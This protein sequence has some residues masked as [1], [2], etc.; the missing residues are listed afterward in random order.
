MISRTVVFILISVASTLSTLAQTIKVTGKIVD[1]Q[2]G[3][4]LPYASVYINHTTIGAYANEQGEFTIFHVPVGTHELMASFVGYMP[5]KTVLQA[6]ENQD[7]TLQIGLKLMTLKA[8]EITAKRD[9]GWFDQFEKF[10]KLFLGTGQSARL[11]NIINPFGLTF[12]MNK[13][14]GFIAE[15]SEPLEID[16][17]YLGYR[18]HYDLSYFAVSKEKYFAKGYIRFEEMQT[19]DSLLAKRWT[20]NRRRS[21]AGSLGHFLTSITEGKIAKNGYDTYDDRSGLNEIVRLARFQSNLDRTIFT[22]TLSK[23]VRASKDSSTFHVSVPKRL[24]IHYKNGRE[25]SKIYWDVSYPVSWI[26]VNGGDLILARDGTVLNPIQMTLSGQMLE[27]RVSGLLPNDYRPKIDKETYLIPTIAQSDKLSYLG[28]KPYLHTDR[29]YY[30]PGESMWFKAYMKYNS[31]ITRDSL[32]RVLYVDLLDKN[33]SVTNSKAYEIRD[34]QCIGDITFPENIQPGDYTLRAYTRWML[35]FDTTF[36]YSVPIKI[37]SLTQMVRTNSEYKGAENVGVSLQSKKEEYSPREMVELSVDVLDEFDNPLAAHLSVSVTDL[38]QA[39]PAK[40]ETSI[41]KKFHMPETKMQLPDDKAFLA[42]QQGF[43]LSG[44]FISA[45]GKKIKGVLTFVQHG[46]ANRFEITT[47]DNGHFFIP[48]M[49]LFDT[50]SI[51]YSAKAYKGRTGKVIFDSVSVSPQT[52]PAIP[53]NV[54]VYET[55]KQKVVD[56]LDPAI[57]T[58]L[59]QS[60][61]IQDKHISSARRPT[62]TFDVEVTGEWLRAR[63]TIDIVSAMQTRVPGMRVIVN[64]V[65]GMPQRFIQL[66]GPSSLAKDNLSQPIVLIDGQVLSDRDESLTDQISRLSPEVI[67]RIEVTKYGNGAAYGARGSNGIIAIYTRRPGNSVTDKVAD[68]DDANLTPLKF[69]GFSI[70]G[71]FMAPD[72]SD[73]ENLKNLPDNRSTIFWNPSITYDGKHSLY[74]NFYAADPTTSYRIVVEGVT[75]EGKPVRT[76]KIIS[77]RKNP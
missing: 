44:S 29:A 55:P 33:N 14:S 46:V 52:T 18:V 74:I 75:A 54:E 76:E 1:A 45:K 32:S 21:Y 41:L 28:E 56:K 34:D 63:N 35:N 77:I 68:I 23:K 72:Y 8:V 20:Q 11:C 25:A 51:S 40:N 3:H 5:T 4:A 16:N 13:K 66:S 7:A 58:V 64:L 2:S 50:A 49:L 15:A 31:N 22:D 69:R 9:A 12:T 36:V 57:K 27:A 43:D 42:I 71:K 6:R 39:W 37:L 67:D 48:D 38:N 47:E 65:D 53:L 59:L 60:V 10:K 30:Y 26:E 70:P 19:T 73:P 62:T 61:T 24:E 17:L